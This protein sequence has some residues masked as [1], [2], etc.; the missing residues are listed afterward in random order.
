MA[1]DLHY[2]TYGAPIYKTHPLIIA[3]GL[4]GSHTNWHRIAKSLCTKRQVYCVDLRNHGASPHHDRMDYPALS[5]DVYHL[6][7]NVIGKPVIILGHSMGGKTAMH[8][9]L[10]QPNWVVKLIVVDVA[11]TTTNDDPLTYIRIMQSLNFSMV[12]NRSDADIQ[13]RQKIKDP[14][15]R[16]FLLQ[17]L[18]II[19][20]RFQWRINLNAIY[21]HIADLMSFDKSCDDLTYPFPALFLRGAWSNYIADKHG[22]LIKSYF[23]GAKLLTVKQAGHWIHAEQPKTFLDAVCNF[24]S[25]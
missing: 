5:G 22:K 3:H 14:V 13:L 6:I 1:V 8:L 20:G 23:P 12:M 21:K 2:R 9:A 15:I 10:T 24:L 11:P 17:N 19:N 18:R 25:D 7:Q 16:Q 4:F